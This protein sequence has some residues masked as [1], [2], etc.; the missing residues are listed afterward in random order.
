[1]ASTD[2]SYENVVKGEGID[3]HLVQWEGLRDFCK[4]LFMTQGMPDND[5]FTVADALVEADLCG[6]PS[7]GTTR[8][9]IYLKRLEMKVVDPVFKPIIE[10]EN[11]ASVLL[12]GNNASGMVVGKYAMEL[13]C[14]KAKENG[15]CFVFVNHSNHLGMV[16][17]YPKIA[18]AQGMLGFATTSANPGIAP[19]GSKQPFLG[20]SPIAIAV[21]TRGEPVVLD[22]APSHVAMGKVVLAAKLGISIPEGW[23]LDEEG[24]PT[25]DPNKGKKGSVV[26]IGGPKGSGLSLFSQILGGIMSGAG[27]GPHVNTLYYDF[28]HP[29]EMGHLFVAV[30]ISKIVDP[31]IFKD[32]METLTREIKSLP[33]IDGV[34]E[35]LMPG[36]IEQRLRGRRKKEG[37]NIP[38]VVYR[39]LREL[40]EKHGVE[41]S[42]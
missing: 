19:W 29:Q 37:I 24:K 18:A 27:Y 2:N 23:A 14:R 16:G 5:A 28:G 35:I 30:D 40:G 1:M 33:R 6:V 31:D 41:F 17:Y 22:M 10:K 4:N 34:E 36:E 12:N 26:P 21:P 7:H 8:T 32:R 38:D 25:T 13:A 42:L 20:T 9:Q 39:E 3:A 15:S 11:P